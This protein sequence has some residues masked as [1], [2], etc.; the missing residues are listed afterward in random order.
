MLIEKR[1]GLFFMFCGLSVLSVNSYADGL[2]DLNQALKQL[3][4]NSPIK[5]TL[6][7]SYSQKRGRKKE[8]KV[9]SGFAQVN[10][11][12]APSGLQVT[13]SNE[14]LIKLEHERNEK[15]TNEEVNTP[16]LNAINDI[17][18]TELS[19][20]LSAASNLK[21]SLIK[22][23]FVNEENILFEG[24]KARILHFDL[25]LEAIITNKEVR[26]Y[27]NDFNGKYNI[28]ID[29]DGV[30]L[31]SELSFDGKGSIYLFFKLSINQSRKYYYRVVDDRLVNFRQ[32]FERKQ[33]ST[34][35]K[36]D[37]SGYKVLRLEDDIETLAY[38]H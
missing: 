31:Q 33:K 25:P 37:S 14:T 26:G 34:W 12:D 11:M 28:T 1:I 35:D 3:N 32:E 17:E 19:S 38:E 21:R 6:E 8:I 18:A 22:A 23:K 30:P 20:M 27:V 13:Y 2:T 24:K 5:A 4:G 10:L 15:E 7:T 16:T 29:D 9:T 36:R